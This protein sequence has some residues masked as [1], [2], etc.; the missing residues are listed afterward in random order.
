MN[1]KFIATVIIV[2]FVIKPESSFGGAKGPCATLT[3][4]YEFYTKNSA[5]YNIYTA[6]TSCET[7]LSTWK[8]FFAKCEGDPLEGQTCSNP[9]PVNDVLVG[10]DLVMGP[11]H[12]YTTTYNIKNAKAKAG[13]NKFLCSGNIGTYSAQCVPN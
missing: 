12:T 5:N 7:G 4:N 13:D 11:V 3:I 8:N 10:S 6:Y 9:A 2:G 1:F